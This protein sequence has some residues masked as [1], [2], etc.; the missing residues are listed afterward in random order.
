MKIK[1]PTWVF[2]WSAAIAYTYVYLANSG[3]PGNTH[4][5]EGWWLWFDQGQY[6]IA[7]KSIVAKDFSPGNFFYPPIYP[8]I[9]AIFLHQFPTHPFFFFNGFAFV[10]FIYVFLRFSERYLSRIEI[11]ILVFLGAYFNH[12][13]MENYVIPWTTAGTLV[14]YSFAI[15][16]LVRFGEIPASKSAYDGKRML[17]AFVFA[18]IFGLLILLRPVDTGLAAVFFP[19]YLYMEHASTGKVSIVRNWRRLVITG[20]MLSLGLLVDVALFVAYNLTIFGNVLGGYFKSTAVASGYFI[21]ELPRKAFSLLFDSYSVYLEPRAA[22]V[23][24]DP[25]LL[26]AMTGLLIA[27]VWGDALLRILTAAIILHFCLYAP[28]GDLLPNGVWRYKNIHYFK[29]MFPYLAL[30]AWLCVRWI[31]IRREHWVSKPGNVFLRFVGVFACITLI[32][33]VR[34]SSQTIVTQSEVAVAP[35]PGQPTIIVTRLPA[36]RKR[37]DFIDYQG[38]SGGFEDDYFGEHHLEVDGQQL[39]KVRDFRIIPA[40]WGVRL[41]F[42]RPVSAQKI[43][44]SAAPGMTTSSRQLT[45]IISDYH[46]SLGRPKLRHGP[47]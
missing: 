11:L 35:I 24:H 18:T 22:I 15:L 1:I 47:S 16:S 39:A 10:W 43:T 34:F 38:L 6:L 32:L 12:G 41:L 27:I 3:L 20:L 7:A 40:P 9:G 17:R 4:A 46:F 5:P 21:S 14:I 31:S 13:V 28:Y 33:S 37:I 25:W 26:L 45:T 30:Y 29:W 2:L 23:S 8:L 44:L 36:E 19:A 42:I